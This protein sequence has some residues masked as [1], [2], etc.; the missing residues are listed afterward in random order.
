MKH[1]HHPII[2]DTTHGDGKH[3]QMFRDNF[4]SDRLLLHSA[5]LAFTH[6]VTGK[7]VEINAPLDATFKSL[8]I[9][10]KLDVN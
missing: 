8:L 9:N 1:L 5:Y 3:N 6:P 10:L 4:D 2:G 7:K